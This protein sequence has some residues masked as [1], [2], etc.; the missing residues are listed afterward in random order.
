[1]LAAT[2]GAIDYTFTGEVDERGRAAATLDVGGPLALRC[3][4]CGRAL[5]LPLHVRARYFFVDDAADLDVLPLE[6]DD[7][8]EPLP[9]G[10]RFDLAAL[11]EDEAILALPISPR[12]AHCEAAADVRT[13]APEAGAAAGETRRPNPFAALAPLKGRRKS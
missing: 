4:L 12:H 9:G 6:A 7:E 10:R 3:D 5:E 11:I 13:A 1:M 2:D 8:R